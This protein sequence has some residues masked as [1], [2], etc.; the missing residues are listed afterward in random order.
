MFICNFLFSFEHSQFYYK[1][2][3]F[4]KEL[5]PLRSVDWY[6]VYKSNGNGKVFRYIVLAPCKQTTDDILIANRK[7]TSCYNIQIKYIFCERYKFIC[8]NIQY[9]LFYMNFERNGF[10][11]PYWRETTPRKHD[12]LMLSVLFLF[13]RKLSFLSALKGNNSYK[14]PRLKVVSSVSQYDEM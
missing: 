11:P 2:M 9:M 12:G 6:P 8:V 14:A 3:R 10:F 5:F 4:L 1:T 13:A 7:F